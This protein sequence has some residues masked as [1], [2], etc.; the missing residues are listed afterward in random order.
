MKRLVIGIDFGTLSARALL[1]DAKNG[2]EIATALFPY[3]HGVMDRT[4]P[5]GT[6][7]ESAGAYQDP[8]D[9][10]EA[11]SYLI[12]EV[13]RAG[14]T[15]PDQIAALGI[16]FTTC[17]VL[18][19][20]ESGT[21]LCT[22]P[23]FETNP[24]AWVKLWKH[25]SASAQAEK[26]TAVALSRKE[27]FLDFY[28]GRFSSEWMLPKILETLEK[29]PEVYAKTH[30]FI[31]AGDWI[32]L[33]LTGNET[34]APAF[35]H[36]KASLVP[37]IGFPSDSY[38]TAVD[39]RLKGLYGT[40]ISTDIAIIG[41]IAGRLNE[42]GAKITSL[43]IGI[44]LSLPILDAGGAMPALGITKEK[45]LLVILGTSG[46][47]MLNDKQA[48][49]ISGICGCLG[50]GI[51]P[52]YYTY[53]AGVSAI[54]DVFDWYLRTCLPKREFDAAR[55]AGK[56]IHAHLRSQVEGD[57]PGQSGLL[58][59]DWLSGDRC[60]FNDQSLTGTIMGLTLQ[61]TPAR[62]YRALIE[63][64]AFGMKRSADSFK[65]TG[66][67]YDRV[68]AAG[69]IAQ[70]DPMLM[71]IYADVFDAPISVAKTSQAGARGAAIY[72][73]HAAG[74]YHSVSD[75]IAA[76]ASPIV[77]TYEPIPENVAIYAKLYDLYVT[78]SDDMGRKTD[79][80]MRSLRALQM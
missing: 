4:L 3:P 2:N 74:V 56:N 30:R 34:H 18:P 37:G 43:P 39:P 12:P 69:G 10:I 77:A 41:Q 19:I 48:R 6:A 60:V 46:V 36:L 16:D 47:L 32:S 68:F 71:Q 24:H 1:M 49:S 78:L 29:A 27:P 79:S 57:K 45:E 21:P 14:E 63:S 62:I 44:P 65:A 58:A 73:S 54:G 31:E 8:R 76:L 40:K 80:V 51:L 11:L 22:L 17:T 28:G 20:D 59:L 53:E 75:A 35:A 25:H 38:L 50:K 64:T 67:T 33:V 15:T 23:V 13:C 9:Y 55:A 61:T 66:M 7:V 52:D 26:L 72:A 5:C 42:R 70:K